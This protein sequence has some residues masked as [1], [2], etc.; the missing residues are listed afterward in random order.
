MT[1]SLRRMAL[2]CLGCCV[3]G[4]LLA[5]TWGCGGKVHD[6]QRTINA[7]TI[8]LRIPDE[9]GRYPREFHALE[10]PPVEYDHAIHVKA[11]EKKG[12]EV[13][14]SSNAD[15]ALVPRFMR[16]ADGDDRRGLM[17][18]YHDKCTGCHKETKAGGQKAGPVTC[19]ECHVERPAPASAW[20]QIDYDYSLHY[21]HVAAT[22][23][24]CGACHHVYDEEA[25]KLVYKKNTESACRDCHG[26]RDEGKTLSLR[27]ASHHDCITCHMERARKKQKAG[28]WLCEGCH[29]VEKQRAFERLASVPRLKR[30][31]PDRMWLYTPEAGSKSVAFNHELHEP[32]TDFCS[33]CHHKTLKACSECHTLTGSTEGNG[34]TLANAYHE[35]SSEYS[36]AGCH[37][38]RAEEKECSGCHY[39]IVR[40][41]S[42]RTCALCHSGPR[43]TTAT[44]ELP[45]PPVEKVELAQLP[46]PSDDFPDK[47]IIDV[48]AK[49][50]QP[51]QLPHQKIVMHLDK[52][53]RESKLASWFHKSPETLCAGC[54]HQSPVGTRPSPCRSCH[55]KASYPTEDRPGL[56]P[57]YH[58]QCLGCHQ[59]M[60]QVQGCTDCHKKASK[61][62]PT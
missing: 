49:D 31:Q 62:V 19:G 45:P 44:P 46:A 42:Q 16:T 33:T 37:E 7:A 14:H 51:V 4:A 48:L 10:R 23:E 25:K 15:G 1:P 27:N 11:L 8:E 40:V 59:K 17:E 30:G 54:H 6:E 61:E 43:A 60:G 12:C 56:Y 3:I 36:C 58:R 18:L 21:R 20:R 22:K 29:G 34:V 26:E 47:V 13:C 52:S 28:P 24:D 53:V 32:L 35:A 38:I 50:Y 57:A 55:E 39:D 9:L 2:G 5:A 41:P